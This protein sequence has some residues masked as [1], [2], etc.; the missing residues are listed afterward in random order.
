MEGGVHVIEMRALEENRVNS[1]MLLKTTS[2]TAVFIRG[3]A[4]RGV[5]SSWRRKST[6]SVNA[7][8]VTTARLEEGYHSI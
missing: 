8:E 5:G 7:T 1:S 2:V 4:S 6:M 3:K